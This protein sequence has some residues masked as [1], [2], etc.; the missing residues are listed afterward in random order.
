MAYLDLPGFTARSTMPSTVVAELEGKE[1]GW[2]AQK[3]E[4]ESRFLDSRL[5]KRYEVPFDEADPPEAICRWLEKI[6]TVEAYEKN[7]VQ[8]DDP[9]YVRYVAA[10]DEAVAEV[11]EAADSDTGLFELPLK[12]STTATAVTRG[13]PFGYSEQS[14]Y[15]AFD[16][17]AEAGRAEDQDGSGTGG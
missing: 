9:Q 15:V 3:L 10:R 8:P 13:G 16:L 14:P 6:V 4:T 7:G 1:A 11:K 17:Q 5:A 2:I 12:G